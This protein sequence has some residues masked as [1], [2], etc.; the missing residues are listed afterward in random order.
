MFGWQAVSN[1]EKKKSPAGHVFDFSLPYFPGTYYHTAYHAA[2]H[3]LVYSESSVN[4]NLIL[5]HL[6]CTHFFTKNNG[7]P[8]PRPLFLVI[9]STKKEPVPFLTSCFSFYGYFMAFLNR[10]LP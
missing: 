6:R 9:P 8:L 1:F 7:I 2:I 5:S 10:S 3:I 4:I